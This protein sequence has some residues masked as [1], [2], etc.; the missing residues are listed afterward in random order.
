MGNSQEEDRK[1]AQH[2]VENQIMP[3]LAAEEMREQGLDVE[4]GFV[5]TNPNAQ[6]F[7]VTCYG[8][9][10]TAKLPFDPGTKVGLCPACARAQEIL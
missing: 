5:N 3:Q 10:K 9:Q 1:L 4:I 8:C 2:V 7:T 6:G